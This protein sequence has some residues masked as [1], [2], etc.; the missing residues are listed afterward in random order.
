MQENIPSNYS[1]SIHNVRIKNF[2]KRIEEKSKEIFKQLCETNDNQNTLDLNFLRQILTLED[3]KYPEPF[4]NIITRYQF[5]DAIKEGTFSDEAYYKK[6]FSCDE[7]TSF[8]SGKE[9]KD[10][11]F[12]TDNLM[13][14]RFKTEEYYKL[15][16]LMGGNSNGLSRTELRRCLKIATD[17][18]ND[19]DNFCDN[20]TLDREVD[21]ILELLS[22]DGKSISI[23]DFINI[24]TC[25]VPFPK[26]EDEL[27]Q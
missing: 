1:D 16:S 25:S 2:E 22:E 23:K 17:A 7:F 9:M 21:E 3:N 26:D 18:L 14:K 4:L 8:I 20:E 15:Y 6:V 27:F 11:L 10:L 5:T 19:R 13:E 24:M 12:E